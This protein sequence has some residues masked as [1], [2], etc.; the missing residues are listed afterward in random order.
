MRSSLATGPAGKSSYISGGRASFLEKAMKKQGMME[1]Q[2]QYKK[3][4]LNS[5]SQAGP[6]AIRVSR[7]SA[8]P[9]PKRKLKNQA[10]RR[11][12]DLFDLKKPQADDIKDGP[13]VE[14]MQQKQ[15]NMTAK[16]FFSASRS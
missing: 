16:N 15:L 14:Q 6:S 10:Q 4:L 9:N 3:N 1:G 12:V 5:Y 11:S 13:P 2:Q 7:L 8:N